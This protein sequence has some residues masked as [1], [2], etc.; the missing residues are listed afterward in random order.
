MSGLKCINAA[1]TAVTCPVKVATA[2]AGV[3]EYMAAAMSPREGARKE[4]V[5]ELWGKEVVVWV[6]HLSCGCG[7]GYQGRVPWVDPGSMGMG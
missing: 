3:Q 2:F 6:R 5:S 1:A 7:K 4:K